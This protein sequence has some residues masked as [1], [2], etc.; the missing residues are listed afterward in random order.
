[1]AATQAV[2]SLHK[3]NFLRKYFGFEIR[4]ANTNDMM[5]GGGG[6]VVVG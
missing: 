5:G 1:M 2:H 3:R 4:T 6:G